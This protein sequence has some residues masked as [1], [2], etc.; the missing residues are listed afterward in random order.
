MRKMFLA[1]VMLCLVSSA[2]SQAPLPPVYRLPTSI[3]PVKYLVHLEPNMAAKTASGAMILEMLTS[4]NESDSLNSIILHLGVDATVRESSVTLLNSSGLKVPIGAIEYDDAN[5]LIKFV[6]PDGDTLKPNGMYMLVLEFACRLYSEPNGLFIGSYNTTSNYI[7]SYFRPTFARNVFPCFDEPHFKT[8][9]TLRVQRPANY[10]AVSTAPFI[11][12]TSPDVNDMVLD[13][14]EISEHISLH[15]LGL[16]ISPMAPVSTMGLQLYA[17][18]GTAT[19]VNYL[20]TLLQNMYNTVGNLPTPGGN[21]NLVVLPDKVFTAFSS[22]G[23]VYTSPEVYLGQEP[24]Q[25]KQFFLRQKLTLAF[26][27]QYLEYQMTPVWWSDLWLSDSVGTFVAMMLQPE[28]SDSKYLPWIKVEMRRNAFGPDFSDS[29]R[30]VVDDQLLSRWDIESAIA[31]ESI[32][33]KGL[34][35]LTMWNDVMP[36]GLVMKTIQ[37]YI[38]LKKSMVTTADLFEL[39]VANIEANTTYDVTPAINLL[40]Y[41]LNT[42]GHPVLTYQPLSNSMFTLTQSASCSETNNVSSAVWPISISY[43]QNST[44]DWTF[45]RQGMWL[46]SSSLDISHQLDQW[47]VFNLETAPYRVNYHSSWDQIIAALKTDLGASTNTPD[48]IRAM[49]QEDA[50]ALALAGC[51]PFTTML[52]VLSNTQRNQADWIATVKIFDVITAKIG[53]DENVHAS[54]GVYVE[55]L[56][57][58]EFLNSLDLKNSSANTNVEFVRAVVT[59]WLCEFNLGTCQQA[60]AELFQHIL[61]GNV[62]GIDVEDIDNVACLGARYSTSVL[63]QLMT[64]YKNAPSPWFRYLYTL[65]LSCIRDPP[66]VQTILNTIVNSSSPFTVGD[67]RTIMVGLAGSMQNSEAIVNFIVTQSSVIQ[68]KLGIGALSTTIQVLG[69]FKV[70]LSNLW[71]LTNMTL[72]LDPRV[73]QSVLWTMDAANASTTWWQNN[74]AALES[75]LPAAPQPTPS[76]GSSTTPSPS[77]AAKS[78]TDLHVFALVVTTI[79]SIITVHFF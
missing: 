5:T 47:I 43:T 25:G 34:N 69:K 1:A 50:T 35:V 62:T 20:E 65:S 72:G 64:A 77:S 6:L 4:R 39:M 27:Q 23:I 75:A 32:K 8:P 15:S 9:I 36:E 19:N 11:N 79:L 53:D 63:G 30:P 12:S 2:V 58:K 44:R 42:T 74:G 40:P 16:F 76:P 10:Y 68:E 59:P 41:W 18:P 3:I 7:A 49:I 24:G 37:N 73:V 60:A 38:Q 57:P 14:F 71:S 26:L 21:F 66:S 17:P 67:A 46:L 55:S 13:T 56:F 61:Q 78:L 51:L 33:Y 22:Y 45:Y 48:V 29:T 28:Y 70:D 54:F 52:S 31:S